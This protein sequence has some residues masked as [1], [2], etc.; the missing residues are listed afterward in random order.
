MRVSITPLA[1]LTLTRIFLT[2][3]FFKLVCRQKRVHDA[4]RA[5]GIPLEPS[6]PIFDQLFD[7]IRIKKPSKGLDYFNKLVQNNGYHF[8]LGV[9]PLPSCVLLESELLAEIL[10]HSNTENYR[11]TAF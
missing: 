2:F 5:Q 11:K 9:G 3:I 1:T 6:V 4:F 10:G 7:E 8:L